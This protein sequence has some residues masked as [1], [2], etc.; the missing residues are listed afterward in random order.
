LKYIISER[1]IEKILF[2]GELALK[3]RLF[4]FLMLEV[5]KRE[6]EMEAHSTVAELLDT[7]SRRYGRNFD[8]WIWDNGSAS[9]RELIHGTIIMVNG[10]H[11]FHLKGL[12]TPL[13]D[14]DVVSIFPPAAGG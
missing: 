10:H 7:L 12:D 1:I 5:G 4:A 6:I 9:E 8:K 3:V 14:S 2:R 11:I 13:S